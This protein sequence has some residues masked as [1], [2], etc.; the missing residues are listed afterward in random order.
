MKFSIRESEIL[1]YDTLQDEIE[2]QYP[3]L[4]YL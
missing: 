3:R 2:V 1:K 4:C